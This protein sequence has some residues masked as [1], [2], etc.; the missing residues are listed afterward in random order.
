MATVLT[1]LGEQ[2]AAERM[3]GTGT[4]SG[5]NGAYIAW[6]TGTGT[7]AKSDTTLFTEA[8]ESRV[9]G[10]VTVTGSGNGAKYQVSG[11]I[12]ADGT[13]SITNAGNWTAST[14]GAL[15]VKGDFTGIPL[16]SGDQITFTITVDPS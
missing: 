5:D 14:G 16:S 3:A 12:T 13:K 10:T 1:N 8:T 15:L 4:Y 2:W 6:G 11:T 9:A 7:A